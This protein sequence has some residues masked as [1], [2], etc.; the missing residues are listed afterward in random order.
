MYDGRALGVTL[1]LQTLG[2]SV[3]DDVS[4]IGFGNMRETDNVRSTITMVE[5]PIEEIGEMAA[6][7]ALDPKA[8]Y[9]GLCASAA[10]RLPIALRVRST[11]APA[12]Q[13]VL[14]TIRGTFAAR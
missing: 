7:L 11:T 13:A 2:Y 4:V 6:R 9:A 3:P 10:V 1:A 8:G 14:P 5:S 12:A